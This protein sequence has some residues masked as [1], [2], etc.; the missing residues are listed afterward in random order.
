MSKYLFWATS[1]CG[2][3][4][5]LTYFDYVCP[6]VKNIVW[7]L[8]MLKSSWLA[9]FSTLTPCTEPMSDQPTSVSEAPFGIPCKPCYSHPKMGKHS[10]SVEDIRIAQPSS[11]RIRKSE[12]V[13]FKFFLGTCFLPN[14]S[15][16][17]RTLFKVFK[18]LSE[19]GCAKSYP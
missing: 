18:R 19:W 9:T 6:C 3:K 17:W 11:M 8:A 7:C 4:I 16:W 12:G 14:C 1:V 13:Y 5:F 2:S 10:W 15:L